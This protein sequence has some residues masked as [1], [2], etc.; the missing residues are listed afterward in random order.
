MNDK[1]SKIVLYA[2]TY[3]EHIPLHMD[4]LYDQ[5][6]ICKYLDDFVVCILQTLHIYMGRHTFHFHTSV[7]LGSRDQSNIHMV[8]RCHKG[9]LCD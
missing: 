8:C 3:L 1:E 9:F 6:N 7:Y 4:L 5:G 2:I